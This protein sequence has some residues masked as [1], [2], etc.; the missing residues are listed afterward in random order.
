MLQCSDYHKGEKV[1]LFT[2]SGYVNSVAAGTPKGAYFG[3]NPKCHLSRCLYYSVLMLE[4]NDAK[5][6]YG[7]ILRN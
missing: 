1:T 2:E 6:K 3:R 4:T 5:L 7:G